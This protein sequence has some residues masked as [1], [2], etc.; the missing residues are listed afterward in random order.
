[1]ESGRRAAADLFAC[2]HSPLRK[3]N[4]QVRDSYFDCAQV[5][6][7]GMQ[8]VPTSGIAR[9]QPRDLP[10]LALELDEAHQPA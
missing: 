6:M 10:R 3:R 7:A 8:R 2:S 1:V 4:E 5:R 9:D